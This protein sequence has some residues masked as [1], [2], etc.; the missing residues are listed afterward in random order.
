MHTRRTYIRVLYLLLRS[1]PSLNA[2]PP[3]D[4]PTDLQGLPNPKLVTIRDEEGWFGPKLCA[5]SF[6]EACLLFLPKIPSQNTLIAATSFS[7]YS[8]STWSAGKTAGCSCAAH[9]ISLAPPP[10]VQSMLLG[11]LC[12]MLHI[13]YHVCDLYSL[14]TILFLMSYLVPCNIKGIK[15]KIKTKFIFATSAF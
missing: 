6:L 13:L 8:Q 9:R 10:Q 2:G 7:S 1:P 5:A 11:V 15:R 14:K 4:L 3:Q 12:C